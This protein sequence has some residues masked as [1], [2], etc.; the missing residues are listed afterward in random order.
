MVRKNN[1][2][3]KSMNYTLIGTLK[4]KYDVQQIS[5]KARKRDF[6]VKDNGN[7]QYPQ[8]VSFSLWQD[9]VLVLDDLKEGDEVKV[10]FYF[11]GRMWKNPKGEERYFNTLEAV[12]VQYLGQGVLDEEKVIEPVVSEEPNTVIERKPLEPMD[13]LPF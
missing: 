8:Y 5:E 3:K 1:R 9:K 11:R 13:D 4:K 2:N 10:S 6:V 12:S 7:H